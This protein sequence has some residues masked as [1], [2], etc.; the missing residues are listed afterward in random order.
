[1]KVHFPCVAKVHTPCGVS[2]VLGSPTPLFMAC[3]HN[4]IV[5][6]FYGLLTAVY[7]AFHYRKGS[8]SNQ[9]ISMLYSK[10]SSL[11]GTTHV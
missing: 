11:S 7:A 5:C 3:L 6:T 4:M 1:M 10:Q 9:T 8:M 2:K